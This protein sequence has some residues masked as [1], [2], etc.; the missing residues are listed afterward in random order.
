MQTCVS[1]SENI[2][3]WYVLKTME[4]LGNKCIRSRIFSETVK[5]IPIANYSMRNT[6]AVVVR[7]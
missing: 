5:K 6:N 1:L 3:F 4:D 2:K 7:I